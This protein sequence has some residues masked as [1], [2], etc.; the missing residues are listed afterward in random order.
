MSLVG[1]SAAAAASD[2]EQLSSV[3]VVF[4]AFWILRVAL[5]SVDFAQLTV[6][7]T[8]L[9]LAPRSQVQC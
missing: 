9:A 5:V 1:E 2:A 3:V 4:E 7:A 8:E 6:P